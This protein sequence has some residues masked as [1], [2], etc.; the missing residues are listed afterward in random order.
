M[1]FRSANV[2]AQYLDWLTPKAS[3]HLESMPDGSAALVRE[4]VHIAAVYKNEMGVISKCSAVCPHLGG[5][6]HWNPVELTWDCPCHGSRFTALGRV[7]E[8]PATMD[9]AVL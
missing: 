4:G 8:G 7:I 5:I 6:V 2:A 3:S 9:L 1:L